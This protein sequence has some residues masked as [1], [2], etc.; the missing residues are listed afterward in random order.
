M[1]MVE[2]KH[3]DGTYH[4][5]YIDRRIKEQVLDKAK[6]N[7]LKKNNSFIGIPDGRSGI[8]KTTETVHYCKYCDPNFTLDNIAWTPK[9]F[10]ELIQNAKKGDAILFDEGM[11]VNSRSATSQVNKAIIIALS[12]IRSRN[13]FIFLCINSIFDLDRSIALHRS[14]V[15]F[16]IYN[17]DDI[18]NGERRI[19]VYGRSKIKMLYLR[20]KKYYSYSSQPNFFAKCGKYVF[21]CN[22]IEYEKRKREETMANA[23]L[24]DNLVGRRESKYRMLLA[25]IL[26]VLKKKYEISHRDIG[27]IIDMKES[28]ISEM[29]RWAKDKGYI[30]ED[31]K[32]KPLEI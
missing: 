24:D 27:G 18:T 7:V 31:E 1:V 12:Q 2:L 10:V 16:H 6:I 15:L 25:K 9:R 30:L 3:D 13:I 11:I 20:G 8:G 23:N 22:E 19:K 26:Y 32:I 21:L 29:I 14:D 17:K 4:K 5:V 28:R